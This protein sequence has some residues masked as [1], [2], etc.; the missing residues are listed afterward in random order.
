VSHDRS[1]L[2]AVSTDILHL[3][4]NQLDSY[5]GSFSYF[6]STRAERRRNIIR[7]YESQKQ[8]RDHLQDF[9]DRWR[10]NAKR[11]AQAQSKIKILEKLP[12]LIPPSQDDMQGMGEGQESLYFKFPEPEKLSPP[13]LQMNQVTF[14]YDSSRTILSDGIISSC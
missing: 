14:G 13:I 3:H 12:P 4:N 5:K 8:Y 6:V 10:Y 9:I 2:D 11:A 1:F 7:E